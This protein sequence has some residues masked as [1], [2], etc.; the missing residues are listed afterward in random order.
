MGFTVG[1]VKA[2][3]QGQYLPR[4]VPS[5]SQMNLELDWYQPPVEIKARWQDEDNFRLEDQIEEI[6]VS[7]I[8]AGEWL[9]RASIWG[10]IDV[11]TSRN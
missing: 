5:D 7:L 9:H 11:T 10:R 2:K 8:V 4:P 1:P 6:A 3:P